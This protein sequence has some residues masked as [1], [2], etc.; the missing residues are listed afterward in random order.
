M[1]DSPAATTDKKPAHGNLATR[2]LIGLI[3]GATA[4]S[5]L[6]WQLAPHSGAPA[7]ESYERVKWFADNVA[8]PVGQVFLRMLFMVVAPLVFCSL[9]LGVSGLGDLRKL[10]KIGMRTLAWFGLTTGLAVILGLLLMNTFEPGKQIDRA[11][12]EEIRQEFKG[13]ADKKVQAAKA[14]TGFSINTFVNIVPKNVVRSASDD[15][16]TLGLIFFALILGAAATAFPAEKIKPFVDWCQVLYDLCVKVLGYAM[17]LAP[18]GVA[19][20]VFNVT[21]KL[22]IDVLVALGYYVFVALLGL[23]IHQFIVLGLLAKW[24]GGWPILDFF[25]RTR[26]LMTTAF[27]T[28]SS[29]ATLPTTINTAVNEFNV[30]RP[31]AG[32]VLPLGATMNMNGTALFEG[33]VVLFLAQVI[34]M[35]LSLAQQAIV[36]CLA[37]LTAIGAAGVPGGSLPLLAL[38]L[39]QVGIPADM[40]ALVLGVDRLVDM[41]R[42]VPNVTSDLICSMWVARKEREAQV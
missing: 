17:K 10:G 24:M 21:S 39:T 1:T 15:S 40:L 8:T 11:K 25:K 4:G 36:V 6:N 19:G 31:L 14:G 23:A 3:V 27:S 18:F 35:D 38:V 12:A 9:F 34:G 42:T 33:A 7:S 5:L 32:F 20:L 41:A 22:G 29:N 26:L 28:S 37:V 13:E 2:I 16:D 30:P